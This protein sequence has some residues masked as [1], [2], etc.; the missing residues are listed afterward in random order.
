VPLREDDEALGIG[1]RD[2]ARSAASLERW[3]KGKTP[4]MSVQLNYRRWPVSIGNPEGHLRDVKNALYNRRFSFRNQE[5]LNRLLMLLQQNKIADERRCAGIIRETL[6]ENE[7]HAL[8]RH[9]ILDPAGASSLR[10]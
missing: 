2:R 5:R 3:I 4:L 1:R 8:P 10:A 6:L 9:I 7:G